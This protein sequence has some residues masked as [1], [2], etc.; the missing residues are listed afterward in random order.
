[1]GGDSGATLRGKSG[2][3]GLSV[4]ALMGISAV[5]GAILQGEQMLKDYSSPDKFVQPKYASLKDMEAV[6]IF[7]DTLYMFLGS[8]AR[9]VECALA[10]EGD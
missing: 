8:C 6:S 9:R 3:G 7:S 10:S 1:M 4:L 5:G 2:W